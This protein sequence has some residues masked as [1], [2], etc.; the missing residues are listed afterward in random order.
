MKQPASAAEKLLDLSF[1]PE[2]DA[3][4]DEL[5]RSGQ[6]RIGVEAELDDADNS[7]AASNDYSLVRGS[8]SVAIQDWWTTGRVALRVAA[9]IRPD[10]VVLAR[11]NDSLVVRTQDGLDRITLEGYLGLIPDVSTLRILFDDGSEWAGEDLR[12]RIASWL[13][14]VE[15]P[16]PPADTAGS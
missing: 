7:D 11:V 6:F 2:A 9:G 16:A 4:L 14:Q 8:G 3:Y 5:E 10:D 15:P 13:T 1:A 12:A